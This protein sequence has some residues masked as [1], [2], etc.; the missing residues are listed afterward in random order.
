MGSGDRA[1][2]FGIATAE[3]DTTDVLE[4]HTQAAR[5]VAQVR[6]SGEPFF[7]VLNTYRFSPH[8]KGDDNRD[9]AE[10][11]ARRERD[12]LRVA[13]AGLDEASRLAIE[14]K[15]E[16]ALAEALAPAEA[17]PDARAAA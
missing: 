9:P 7:L 5:A 3:L 15:C 12:P 1:Q 10:I 2:A 4:I 13:A 17:A 11:E 6:A 8:S 16:L 14:E